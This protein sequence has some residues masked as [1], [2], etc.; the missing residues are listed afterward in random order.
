[1]VSKNTVIAF[2]VCTAVLLG[3][4]LVFQQHPSYAGSSARAGNYV[5]ATARLDA[6]M[7]TDLLWLINVHT[8]RLVAYGVDRNGLIDNLGSI[9][10]DVIFQS[11]P[12]MMM[13]EPPS[14]GMTAP[15]APRSRS[16]APA[17]PRRRTK[18]TVV[19]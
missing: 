3:V 12:A 10:L 13:S 14:P 2:L 16:T 7:G 4:I 5:V 15:T 19:P 1:M 11:S 17:V 9:N 18:T 6:G 8:K